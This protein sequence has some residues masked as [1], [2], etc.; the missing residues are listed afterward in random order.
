MASSFRIMGGGGYEQLGE[1]HRIC[2]LRHLQIIN[3]F[4]RAGMTSELTDKL[5]SLANTSQR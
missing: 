5:N 3:I 4:H 1:N 2:L